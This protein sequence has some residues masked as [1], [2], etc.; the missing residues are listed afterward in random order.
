[1]DLMMESNG[2][3]EH[4]EAHLQP[5]APA[6]PA[7]ISDRFPAVCWGCTTSSSRAAKASYNQ[8]RAALINN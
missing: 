7:V 5:V 4:P 2:R 8:H 3:A 1:M 6:A